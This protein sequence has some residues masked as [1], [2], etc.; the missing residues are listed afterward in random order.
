MLPKA[1]NSIDKVLYEAGHR[2]AFFH[3]GAG[4]LS[5]HPRWWM[6]N[7]NAIG[8]ENGIELVPRDHFDTYFFFDQS[9]LDRALPARP[10]WQP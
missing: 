2:L 5:A 8:F 7:G 1:A 6:Q 9:L 3:A 10:I 4:F